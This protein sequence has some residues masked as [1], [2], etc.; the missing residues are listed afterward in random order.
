[1]EY[2]TSEKILEKR[3]E[4]KKVFL[5]SL[6][7]AARSEETMLFIKDS[8]G[9]DARIL[10]IG[11][12]GSDFLKMLKDKG[13]KNISGFDIDNYVKCDDVRDCVKTG[14]LNFSKMPFEDDSFDLIAAFQVMEHLE[15][16]FHFE[17]EA[18]RL[19]KPA[20]AL[21]LAI[22]SGQSLWSRLNYFVSNNVTG[23]DMVNNH[24]SFLPADVFK[25]IFLK[26]FKIVRARYNKGFAP[27]LPWLKLPAHKLLSKQVCY[28]LKRR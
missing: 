12:G 14:D 24:I 23:Y 27:Y 19:L 17:R 7:W 20:G 15:N 18:V 1:M 2:L 9:P 26:D 8:I 16:P 25:K 13:Y 5:S 11:C 21:I 10:D 22:P 4:L 28:F 6:S 3:E